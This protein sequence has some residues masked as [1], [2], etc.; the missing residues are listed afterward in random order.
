MVFGAHRS[1]LVS[2]T[3]LAGLASP[4]FAHVRRP[5]PTPEEVAWSRSATQIR[6]T[7]KAIKNAPLALPPA[8]AGVTDIAFSDLFAPVV[9]SGGL[10]YTTK[11]RAL[12][13]QRVRI[14]GYMVKQQRRYPGLF[15]FAPLPVSTDEIE[16]G[17]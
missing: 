6:A 9:G 16:Y 10:E 13:G 8:P 4:L 14:V 17:L 11:I 15:L 2:A 12:D 1:L 7:L 3:F 5:P